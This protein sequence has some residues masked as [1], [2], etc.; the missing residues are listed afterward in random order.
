MKAIEL[1]VCISLLFCL[2]SCDKHEG[3]ECFYVSLS[4]EKRVKA[5]NED[6][7]ELEGG[8]ITTIPTS[9]LDHPLQ[10]GDLL[11][12]KGEQIVKGACV[13]L[14]ITTVTVVKRH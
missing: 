5:V 8:F 13:P 3:G 12:I 7:I 9:Y 10:V 4:E 14:N 6:F 11:H 2:A 1:I